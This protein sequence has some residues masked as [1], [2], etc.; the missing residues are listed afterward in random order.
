MF[1]LVQVWLQNEGKNIFILFSLYNTYF[2]V[3]FISI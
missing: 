3:D 1:D 2:F